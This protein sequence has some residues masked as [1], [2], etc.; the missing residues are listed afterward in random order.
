[1]SKNIHAKLLKIQQGLV[2]P[3]EQLNKHMGFKYRNAEDILKGVKPLLRETE[4]SLTISDEIVNIA[5]RF[6]VKATA[7]LTDCATAH[8]IEASAYAREPFEKRGNDVSQVTGATSSYARK[9]CLNGLFC[10]DD[11]KDADAMDNNYYQTTA[12]ID[13][14]S[15]LN[16][17]VAM[18]GKRKDA[19][20]MWRDCNSDADSE[21]VLRKMQLTI[22]EYE[23][24]S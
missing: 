23:E 7:I 2:V 10:L 9:Y 21:V 17:H 11:T 24:K 20:N 4:M 3:K 8:S 14:F 13:R 16:E 6:Y 18:E 5:D 15:K 19:K 22:D 1:M 12:L